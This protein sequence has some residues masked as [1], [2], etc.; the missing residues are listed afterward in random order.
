MNYNTKKTIITTL[1]SC[2]FIAGIFTACDDDFTEEDALNAQQTIDLSIYVVDF[3]NTAAM[4]DFNVTILQDG[5][6]ISGTTNEQG[7]ATFSD[8]EI[9]GSI[10]V[11]VSKENYTTVQRLVDVDVTNF[12]QGQRTETIA[13]LSLTENTATIQGRLEIETD[14]TN[15]DTEVVPEGTEV[16]A[17][18]TI[19]NLAGINV[20]EFTATT[21]A[22]GNYELAVPATGNG[23]NYELVYETLTLD[24]TI[25]KNG[26][27]GDPDFPETIP[28]VDNIST[29]FNPRGFS[30]DVP[31]VP[32]LVA[33]V[34]A[35]AN[36]RR[37]IITNVNTSSDGVITNINV[38][39]TG[40]GYTGSEVAVTITSLFG[41]TGADITIP[42]V[43]G[44][45]GQLSIFEDINDGGT[46]YPTFFNANRAV[47]SGPDFVS[48]VEV[49]TAEILTV[50][51][52]YGTGTFRSQRIQ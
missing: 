35:P 48:F 42:V 13:V 28:S 8:V 43:V 44:S 52:D 12:R 22:S 38:F 24:Q 31:F 9:G 40:S 16:T 15:E 20:I 47:Q 19:D 50:N 39:N 37:A 18:L 34:P 11:T 7:V 46:G 32:A 49:R 41:G 4:Q 6:T 33:T 36:G 14:V 26:N 3:F 25:A 17:I 2:L 1:L 27:E 45:N 10:P 51:G 5:A 30:V 29:V 23:I 21:D